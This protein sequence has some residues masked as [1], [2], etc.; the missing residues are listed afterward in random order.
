MKLFFEGKNNYLKIAK[1]K[2]KRILLILKLKKRK[3][4]ED[5][6][7]YLKL[8]VLVFLFGILIWGSVVFLNRKNTSVNFSQ[9]VAS[10]TP[11]PFVE[12]PKSF[13]RQSFEMSFTQE[14]SILAV[15]TPLTIKQGSLGGL[16]GEGVAEESEGEGVFEYTVKPGD[17]LSALANKFNISLNTILWANDLNTRSVIKPGQKLII[18]PVSGVIY[19][20]KKGDTLSDIAKIY[21]GDVKKI[22]DF[23]N[24]SDEGDIFIG[25]ILII[26]GGTKPTSLKRDTYISSPQVPIGSSYFI[27]PHSACRITQGLHW[28]NAVDFGGHCGDSIYAAAGGTVQRVR[29]GWNGGAGNYVTILHPNG[30]VTMYGHIQASLVKPGQEVSQGERIAIMGGRP[31]MP[32]AGISTGC[33]VHFG[34]RGARNPFAR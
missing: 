15:S 27:C 4:S 30:V 7:F 32:G 34:V 22:I 11:T 13:A 18:L 12:P 2:I 1:E 5:S 17:S 10:L 25:D 21:K 24:L 3:L 33:H 26:P 29:Y 6:S 23:N 9:S 8:P 19:H 31:G 28:Y 14:N 16:L 20:V